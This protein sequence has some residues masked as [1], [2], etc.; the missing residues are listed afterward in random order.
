MDR[1]NFYE[2]IIPFFFF[3]SSQKYDIVQMFA[4]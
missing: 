3:F 2:E 4:V 1:V